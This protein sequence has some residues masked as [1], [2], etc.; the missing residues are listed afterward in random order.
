MNGQQVNAWDYP[1][2][3]ENVAR[4]QM[5]VKDLE[6]VHDYR[7]SNTERLQAQSV[8]SLFPSESCLLCIAVFVRL[9]FWAKG[10]DLIRLETIRRVGD[11]R[12][13]WR[14]S[15]ITSLTQYDI[16]ESVFS[17]VR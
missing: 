3:P 5:V 4:L 8:P 14:H 16:S 6:V 12:L 17:K 7:S 13:L 2:T 10:S 15:G 9:C 11:W 1:A